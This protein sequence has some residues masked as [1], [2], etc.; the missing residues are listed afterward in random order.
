MAGAEQNMSR[1]VLN[2]T[3]VGPSQQY[4]QTY[5]RRLN[6][7]LLVAEILVIKRKLPQRRPRAK[8]NIW[9]RQRFTERQSIK[10]L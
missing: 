7:P 8:R 3:S 9:C 6:I 4:E 10:G 5:T 1:E 2:S